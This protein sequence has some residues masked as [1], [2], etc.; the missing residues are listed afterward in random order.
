MWRVAGHCALIVV[1]LMSALEVIDLSGIP[2]PDSLRQTNNNR[3]LGLSQAAP[4]S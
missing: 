1:W 3:L 2:G 4:E